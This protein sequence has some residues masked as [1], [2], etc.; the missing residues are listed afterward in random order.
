[1]RDETQTEAGMRAYAREIGADEGSFMKAFLDVPA[2]SRERFGQ[3]ARALF[4]LANQLS[5]AAYMNVQQARFITGRRKAEDELR[6]K[7]EELNAFVEK[8]QAVNKEF[9]IISDELKTKEKALFD[10][11]TFTEVLLEHYL[12]RAGFK[13]QKLDLLHGWVFDAWSDS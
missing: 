1:V 5:A 10:E 4:T 6:T 2:M 9:T 11:K 8:L 13:L 3:I 12:A 7:N